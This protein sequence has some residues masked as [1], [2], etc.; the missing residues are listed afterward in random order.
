MNHDYIFVQKKADAHF[1][2]NIY[3]VGKIYSYTQGKL[4]GKTFGVT[5]ALIEDGVMYWYASRASLAEL[6]ERCLQM[7][8]K[9][10]MLVAKFRRKFEKL[11]PNMLKFCKKIGQTELSKLSDKQLAKLMDE[12]LDKYEN[13]YVWSEPVV[14]GLND[15]LGAYLKDYLSKVSDKANMVSQYYNILISPV[16]ESFVKREEED[17]LRL[18]I[19]LE[20]GEL[21][22]KMSALENHAGKYGWIPYDYGV[23]V[24]DEKYFSKVLE[25]LL[26]EGNSKEKLF[27]SRKYFKDLPAKQNEL[28]RR[29]KIDVRH[30]KLFKAMRDGAFLLDY[31]KEIFTQAH[32]QINKLLVEIAQRHKVDKALIQYYLPHEL[33]KALNTGKYLS[34][35]TLRRRYGLALARWDK[36]KVELFEGEEGRKYLKQY[37]LKEGAAQTKL[38]GVIASAGKYLGPVKILHNIAEIAKMKKGDVLVAAMTSPE[39]V[40]AM[41][42]AG[43]IIT[44]EGG[45][46]CHAAIVSRE[47]GIPCIVGTRD[48]TKILQDGEIVEVNANH[49]SVR[50]IK[51]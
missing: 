38:D 11:A 29:L 24:W 3:M 21:K 15:S 22:N 28:V 7:L 51:Q 9:D 10:P 50:I 25:K 27:A 49:N 33:K 16:E 20:S 13:I 46:M 37:L 18:A 8:Q 40:P 35:S 14:L 45:V 34:Q 43:A 47:L 17:L 41:R 26:Q 36:D 39:Y 42:L 5:L 2:P 48:A 30:Q 32:W 19:K 6:G 31:K 12:Y 4:F 23:Y 1:F 44:D